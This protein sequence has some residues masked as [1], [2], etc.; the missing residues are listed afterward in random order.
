[1]HCGPIRGS[2]GVPTIKKTDTKTAWWLPGT[3]HSELTL[4]LGGLAPRLDIIAKENKH[5]EK[6]DNFLGLM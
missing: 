1:M 4:Q 3:Q 6:Q 2:P 5:K